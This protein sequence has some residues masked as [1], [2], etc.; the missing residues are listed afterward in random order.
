[1]VT[2]ST[3][4]RTKRRPS[5]STKKKVLF[6]KIG[7]PMESAHWLAFAKG[8]GVYAVD[9]GIVEPVVGVQQP[10]RSTRYWALP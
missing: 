3:L 1:M 10:G 2:V 9:A 8:R 5:L 4:G 7:P 6:L